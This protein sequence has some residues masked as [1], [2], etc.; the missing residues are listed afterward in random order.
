MEKYILYRPLSDMESDGVYFPD[1]IREKL[2]KEREEEVCHYSGLPSL[3]MY[4]VKKEPI[5]EVK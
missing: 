5:D 1:Y 3:K 2:E 4:M